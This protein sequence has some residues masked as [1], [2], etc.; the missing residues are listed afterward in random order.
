M[1][2]LE[3][4]ESRKLHTLQA[5]IRRGLTE[6]HDTLYR[7]KSGLAGEEYVDRAWADF[8]LE[9]PYFLLHNYCAGKHQMDTVFL[10]GRFILIVEIKHMSGRISIEAEKAQFLRIKEDGSVESF[11]NPVDQVKRHVRFME[12]LTARRL[13]V[14][15]AIIFSHS[16]TIIGQVP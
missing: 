1:I 14:L 4:D 11:R 13:P 7:M 16:R 6:W 12:H 10:C 9:E 8:Q 2:L 5:A 3:R 15:Y